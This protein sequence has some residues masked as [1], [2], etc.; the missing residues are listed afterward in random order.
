MDLAIEN[1]APADADPALHDLYSRWAKFASSGRLPSVSDMNID[2]LV[3]EC[4]GVAVIEVQRR[5]DLSR[6]YRYARVGSEHTESLG[7]DIE[8]YYIDELVAP[9]QIA[10]FERVYDEIVEKGQPHYWMRM[11][12]LIGSKIHTFERL[13]VPVA[14][15]GKTV[16]ALIGVWVWFD[17]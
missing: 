7:R 3:A 12:A 11:N 8:G 10:H 2:E 1:P 6:R 14:E 4:P 5:P 16:D 9:Q 17:L 13:L 15:D